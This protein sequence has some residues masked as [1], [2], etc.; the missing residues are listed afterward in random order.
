M[1][2]MG[3]VATESN[4]IRAC[5]GQGVRNHSQTDLFSLSAETSQRAA[6]SLS[7]KNLL[8]I[9]HNLTLTLSLSL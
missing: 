4:D 9:K 1:S 5:S 7:S 8:D 2:N 3:H 6:D